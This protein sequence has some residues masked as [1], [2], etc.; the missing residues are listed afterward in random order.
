M[1][2]QI[3]LSILQ[4]EKLQGKEKAMFA[5]FYLMKFYECNKTYCKIINDS[6]MTSAVTIMPS[7]PMSDPEIQHVFK[8]DGGKTLC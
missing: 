4:D 1:F 5:K 6:K 2:A 7:L 3:I 8:T